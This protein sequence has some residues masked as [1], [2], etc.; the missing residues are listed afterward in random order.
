MPGINIATD[1]ILGF[2]T[3][4]EENFEQTMQLIEK[5]NFSSL[6]INQFYP[7]PGTPAAKM[8]LIPP[9][10]V[11]QRTQR[12]SKYFRSYLPYEGRVGQVYTALV[13]EVS[14]DRQHFVAHNEFYEQIL[15]PKDDYYLGL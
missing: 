3:E 1:L 8:K 5:Y 2:P 13:T 11:R 9:N 7:R 12:A 14:S 6:F 10:K 15:I 4:T